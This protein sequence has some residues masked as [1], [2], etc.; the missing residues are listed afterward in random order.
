MTCSAN[1]LRLQITNA[2]PCGNQQMLSS[3]SV[4]FK[5]SMRR[6]GKILL[7]S[8]S[9]SSLVESILVVD[10]ALL[11]RSRLD[12][13]KLCNWC[14][15]LTYQLQAINFITLLQGFMCRCCRCAASGPTNKTF[16]AISTWR[17]HFHDYGSLYDTIYLFNLPKVRKEHSDA[18][19]SSP[20]TCCSALV[21]NEK[22]DAHD[23]FRTSL[24]FLA[25]SGGGV[26]R[27]KR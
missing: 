19:I 1:K 7:S 18:N 25:T 9:L 26:A 20:D 16:Y 23:F 27:V 17:G 22:H 4:S 12:R 2:R 5:I 6:C 8:L 13:I 10:S 11:D 15:C 21:H 3:Y 14:G 24:L